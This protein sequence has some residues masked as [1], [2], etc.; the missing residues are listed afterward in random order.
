MTMTI[1]MMTMTITMMTMTI[2]MMTMTITMALC[3]CL[4][5]STLK[6]PQ[7]RFHYTGQVSLELLSDLASSS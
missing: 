5:K 6:C 2:T 4:H 3:P 7:A 1:T